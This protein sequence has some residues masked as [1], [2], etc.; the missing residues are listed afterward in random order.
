VDERDGVTE[1]LLLAAALAPLLAA[2]VF[3]CFRDPLRYAL[4]PYALLIPFSDLLSIAPGPFGSVSSLLGLLLGVALVAQLIT[5]RQGAR[6]IPLAVPVWLAFL[7]LS[8]LSIYWSVAARDTAVDFAVLASQVL[9]FVAVVLTRFDRVTL[10]RFG[11]AI[12]LGGVL[13]VSYGLFH[14][15]FLGGLPVDAGRPG[16]PRFGDDL[17]GANNQAAAMLLPLAIAVGRVLAEK[18]RSRLLHTVAALLIVVGVIM[19]GSRGGLLA[20]LVVLAVVLWLSAAR[21][22]VKVVLAAAAVVV[23]TVLLVV[24]P[25][26]FGKRQ[27]EREGSSGRAD[28]WAVGLYACRL[29]CLEGAGW[30][31]FPEVYRQELASVPEARIQERG[32]T[33]EPHNIFI[34]AAVEVGVV[35]LVLV[36]LALWVALVSAW[37]L[38]AAMRGPPAA[39]LLG[40]IVSSFFLSNLGYKFF[41]AVL[42][43][44]AVCETVAAASRSRT[45]ALPPV[46]AG[47]AP[48]GGR[49]EL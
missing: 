31:G 9:L 38:P 2:Y 6:H 42:T 43:Y 32:A 21:V 3:A 22:S 12:L 34:L 10:R 13:V 44:V 39:A 19:T 26:G 29:Y 27:V 37:R 35:G 5:A 49:E 16:T 30:G 33:F 4:P 11:T 14:V 36:V 41:W 40:T 45:V 46:P 24:Q 1:K 25:G 47:S 18:G 8:G 20:T 15:V 7:A 28:I 17:L 48:S 23:L